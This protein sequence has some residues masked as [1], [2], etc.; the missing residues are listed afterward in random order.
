MS[1]QFTVQAVYITTG[2]AS[3]P[4]HDGKLWVN[5]DIPAGTLIALGT[6]NEWYIHR[7]SEREPVYFGFANTQPVTLF[8]DYWRIL[9]P[10]DVDTTY[11]QSILNVPKSAVKPGCIYCY[12]PLGWVKQP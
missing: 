1:R 9:V 3:A 2:L 7:G 6:D 5:P 12:G 11:G 8:R 10:L 4:D